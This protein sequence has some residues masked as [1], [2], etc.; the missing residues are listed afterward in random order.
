MQCKY[1]TVV[2][3]GDE[4]RQADKTYLR[5]H[6]RLGNDPARGQQH[7]KKKK[8]SDQHRNGP[9][10]ARPRAGS[11]HSLHPRTARRR[12]AGAPEGQEQDSKGLPDDVA[13]AVVDGLGDEPHEPDA[14]AAVHQVDA[15]LH[16]H[17][18]C[19]SQQRMID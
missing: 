4:G 16:L 14:A 19:T 1:G 11:K 15:A 2:E 6:E 9:S 3:T 8:E 5:C 18:A 17:T 12:A 10:H 7:D 13:A